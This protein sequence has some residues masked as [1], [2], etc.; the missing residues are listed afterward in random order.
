MNSRI[1]PGE[2]GRFFPVLFFGLW[3]GPRDN[4]LYFMIAMSDVY[5]QGI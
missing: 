4:T 5:P 1:N 3:S 2:R